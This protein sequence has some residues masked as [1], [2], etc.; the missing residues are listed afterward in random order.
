[1]LGA[2]ADGGEH[3]LGIGGGQHED[4]VDRWLL[5]GLQQCVRRRR[6]EHVD[7]VDDVDLLATRRT[8]CGPGHQVAHGLDSVVGRC[9]QLVDVQ[10]AP[11]GDLDAGSTDTTRLAVVEV[12]AIEG[13]GQDPRRGGLARPPRTAEQ[14]GMGHPPVPHR[15]PECQDHMVLTPHLAEGG[16]TEPPVERLEGGVVWCI[17]HVEGAYRPAGSAF[18]VPPRR[19]GWAGHSGPGVR[20]DGQVY[21]GTRPDLL[22]AAAFRP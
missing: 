13:L 18:P 11:L 3:L 17:G 22:R 9:V 10:R 6:R 20:C 12:G 2:A 7:L 14:V 4:D 5:Q 16:R 15:I 1:M 8:Q 19:F 21:C